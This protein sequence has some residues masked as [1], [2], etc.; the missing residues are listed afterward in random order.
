MKQK[1]LSKTEILNIVEP[2]LSENWQTLKDIQKLTNPKISVGCIS[3]IIFRKLYEKI[4]S[5]LI[6]HEKKEWG[7]RQIFRLK[8]T[9][10]TEI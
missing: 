5:S 4:E 9:Y 2:I 8:K 10:E 3:M 6:Y 1:K 7:S